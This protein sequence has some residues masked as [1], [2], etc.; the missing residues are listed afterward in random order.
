[1]FQARNLAGLTLAALDA[2]D[3]ARRGLPRRS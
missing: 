3:R 1:M 2:E